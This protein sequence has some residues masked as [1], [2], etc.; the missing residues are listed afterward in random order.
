MPTWTAWKLSN[1]MAIGMKL[2][3]FRFHR[4]IGIVSDFC[5]VDGDSEERQCIGTNSI[6]ISDFALCLESLW[7]AQR[8]HAG[9]DVSEWVFRGSCYENCADGTISEIK[10]ETLKFV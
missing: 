7:L 3:R 4:F 1:S 2:D 10:M 6:D 9:S 5:Y 8:L